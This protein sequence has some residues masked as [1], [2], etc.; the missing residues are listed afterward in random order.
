M[1]IHL[2]PAVVVILVLGAGYLLLLPGL[3]KLVR[4]AKTLN[5]WPDRKDE[6]FSYPW[7][8]WPEWTFALLSDLFRRSEQRDIEYLEYQRRV[9]WGAALIVIGF[10]SAALLVKL[11]GD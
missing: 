8:I 10:A 5:M 6:P 9:R 2:W 4:R 1:G 11:S 7:A 3:R